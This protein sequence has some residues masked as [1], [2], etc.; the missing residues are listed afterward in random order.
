MQ[1][2]K[3]VRARFWHLTAGLITIALLAAGI[4]RGR[5]VVTPFTLTE[6][7]IRVVDPGQWRFLPDGNV[8]VRNRVN[9][10]LETASD[11][12][13]NGTFRATT[14]ANLDA[15]WT[16]PTWGTFHADDGRA[17][18]DGIW[19]GNFNFHTG[20]GDYDAVG[21]GSGEYAGLQVTEHCVYVYG[22]GTCTGRILE[23]NRK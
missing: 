13:M 11:P 5:N 14:N 7:T 2:L 18:W 1:T 15:S 23:H 19:H 6:T 12:R 10:Y 9:D 16:G 22:V 17:G 3:F 4:A 8:H 21:H 20:S